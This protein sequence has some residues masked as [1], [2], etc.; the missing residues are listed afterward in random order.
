MAGPTV[1][2]EFGGDSD[3]LVREARRAEQATVG[4]SEAATESSRDMERA[5]G[6]TQGLGDRMS[7]LGNTV[8]GAVDSFDAIAGSVQAFADIQDAGRASAARMERALIDVEQAQSDLNQAVLD[9]NQATIDAD[10]ARL[11]GNQALIDE[12]TALEDLAAAI[13]EYGVGSTEALQAQQ[14]LDQARLDGAQAT[15]DYEQ[16]LADGTQSLVDARSATQDLADAQHEVDPGPMQSL[17]NG[18]A[19]FAPLLSGVVSV[20]ALAT[21]AQWSLNFAFLANPI[22][23]V[24]AGI[25]ALVAIIVLIATKTTWFQDA[26]NFAWMKIKSAASDAWNFI[27][28]IPG[29]I[30]SAFSSVGN[31]LTAPF[32]AAFGAIR[33][34][35]NSTVGGFGFSIPGW[36]PF[37]GG[38]SFRLPRMHVGGTVGGAQGQESMAILQAGERVIPRGQVDQA[39][40]GATVN[41]KGNTSDALAT[42]IMHLIRTGQIQ[43]EV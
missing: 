19:T 37:V 35:W 24:I 31:A 38:N 11:D 41:F 17:A 12:R 30:A 40:V 9:G 2:L 1:R 21:A 5:A 10:Q 29:W 4:V 15:A 26:W 42:A 13:D 43:I 14:D 3:G 32:R 39:G 36:V 16:A 23:W 34:L 28:Q 33:S 22:T 18:F 27:R 8:T 20:I 7:N 25:I 6:S